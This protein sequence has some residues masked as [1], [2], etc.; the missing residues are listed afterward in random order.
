MDRLRLQVSEMT[1]VAEDVVAVTL[2][3]TDGSAL[4]PW[5][6]GAHIDLHLPD[7][8]VRQYSLCGSP[9]DR[10]SYTVAVLRAE[11]S[12]GGSAY[13]HSDL[14]TGDELPVAGPRNNFIFC[15]ADRYLFVAGGIG[16]TPILPMAE[17]ATVAGAEWALLY[18]GRTRS[19][20]AFTERLARAGGTVR[21]WPE[22]EHGLLD[23]EEWL[24]RRDER[25]LVYCCGPEGLLRSVEGLAAGWPEGVLHLERFTPSAPP[26]EVD[27]PGGA[28]DVVCA[29]SGTTVEVR[30]GQSVLHALRDAGLDVESSC[31]EGVCGTCETK[32]L[33]G[34]PDHRDSILTPAERSSGTQMMI[35]VSRAH[36]RSLVLDV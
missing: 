31:E 33:S 28:F 23:L 8:H 24:A 22:D 36:S 10:R 4:S 12:R 6:P 20:M 16:I 15:P 27:G 35:C 25:T 14:R 19:S 30:P 17:A 11:P 9:H 29:R 34:D 26:E 13:I 2:S 3:A 5:Q 21:L 1:P 18:G 7:G 32:V